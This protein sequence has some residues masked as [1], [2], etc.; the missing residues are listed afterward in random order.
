M[1]LSDLEA[2]QTL[3]ERGDF[4]RAYILANRHLKKN[5][6]D[7]TW[8]MV[9][10]YIMLGTDK[11]ILAY[12]LAK[13]CVQLQPKNAGGYMNLGMACKDLRLDDEALRYCKR[14]LKLSGSDDQKQMF[15]VNAAS[16]L[17]DTGRFKEAE[18]YCN[19]ALKINPGSEKAIANLGFCQIA[20]RNWK[21]GWKNYRSCLGHEW[22][23]IHKYDKEPLWDGK[24]EGTI[25]LYGEQGLGDQISFASMLPDV[26]DWAK[27]HNSRIILDVSNR[28]ERLIRRSFPDLTVYG[29]QGKQEI[30]WAKDD[31]SIDYSLPIGQVAEYFRTD[32]KDFPGT[33]YLVADE[34]RVLQWRALFESK[35]KPVIGIAWSGGIPKT[36]SQFRQMDLERLLPVLESVDAHWVSLQYK[37]ASKEIAA[38]KEKHPH[39]DIVEYPHGTLSNDY[40]DTVAMVAALDHVV[41]MHTTVIHVAGGLGVPCWTFVPQN[42]QWRYGQDVEDYIWADSVRLI[43]QKERGKWGADIKRTAGELSALFPRV[44]EATRKTA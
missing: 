11:P 28:L 22:R 6:D 18:H 23:P 8:L 39:I 20:Q 35:E 41:A 21:E 9:M 1:K 32:D 33:P 17:V 10:T 40:D 2:A 12:H 25:V 42:S 14:G 30:L 43:R 24:G 44:P 13:R 5:P 34:D 3:A 19:Q 15:C 31:R 38:F 26:M 36:G 7:H 27:R 29:T 4:D 16:V 37:P